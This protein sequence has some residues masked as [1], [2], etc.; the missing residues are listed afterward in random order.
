[1]ATGVIRR[2]ESMQH[3]S[4][5]LA[6]IR[7]WMVTH[8]ITV[9]AQSCCEAAVRIVYHLMRT[10]NVQL[11]STQTLDAVSPCMRSSDRAWSLTWQHANPK[12]RSR[13]H[14]GTEI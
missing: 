14:L 3:L 7:A 8:M 1:M 12:N 5:G 11:A 4:S 6:A 10:A 9:L 2:Y 13:G